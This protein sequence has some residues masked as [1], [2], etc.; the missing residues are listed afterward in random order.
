MII[1][2]ISKLSIDQIRFLRYQALNLGKYNT[3]GNI[4]AFVQYMSLVQWHVYRISSMNN[5]TLYQQKLIELP[6]LA[7]DFRWTERLKTTF[8]FSCGDVVLSLFLC[9]VVYIFCLF[10]YFWGCWDGELGYWVAILLTVSYMTCPSFSSGNVFFS[11]WMCSTF[12]S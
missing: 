7:L 8:L 10:C 1:F 9:N 4:R 11:G 5:C 3:Y 12:W 2:W 6:L